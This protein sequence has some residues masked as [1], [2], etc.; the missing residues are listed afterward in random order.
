MFVAFFYEWNLYLIN[1]L[2]WFCRKIRFRGDIRERRYSA[3]TITA[4]SQIMIFIKKKSKIDSHCAESDCMLTNTVQN[5][6]P[7]WLTCRLK[8]CH[9]RPLLALKENSLFSVLYLNFDHHL[10]KLF[11]GLAYK[12]MSA[13]LWQTSRIFG[14]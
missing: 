14:T 6:T 2:K 4:Q 9:C 13:S 5:L 1:R 10:C 12:K 3:S 11:D 8:F 7:C